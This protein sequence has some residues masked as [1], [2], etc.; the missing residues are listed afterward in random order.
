MTEDTQE[1]R[2]SN[3]GNISKLQFHNRD[4]D[5]ILTLG[6]KEFSHYEHQNV[7]MKN[8]GEW[9]NVTY[10]CFILYLIEL[11]RDNINNA[12]INICL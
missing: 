11:G 4:D 8:G 9:V 1:K 10:L 5:L 7:F 6:K 12:T 3:K 2:L